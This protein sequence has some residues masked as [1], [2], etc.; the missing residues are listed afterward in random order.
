MTIT[1]APHLTPAVVN[2]I[3]ALTVGNATPDQLKLV[4]DALS[5]VSGGGASPTST[6][7]NTLL[8]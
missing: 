4:L 6:A 5:R 2:P 1:P 8:P 7:V 3:L